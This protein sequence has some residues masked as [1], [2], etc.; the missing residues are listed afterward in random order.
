M[1]RFNVD[2]DGEQQVATMRKIE[3]KEKKNCCLMKESF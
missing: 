1:V 2:D 3:E